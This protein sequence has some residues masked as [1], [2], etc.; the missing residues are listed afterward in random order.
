MKAAGEPPAS[1]WELG[2]EAQASDRARIYQ[3]RRDLYVSERD[4]HVHYVDDVH[5]ARR[6]ESG[7]GPEECPYPGL[8]AFEAQQAQWFFGRDGLTADLLVRL[9]ER[10]WAGGPL[11]VV[12]PSG[13]GKSSLLRAG[14]LPALARGALPVAGSARWPRALLTPTVHPLDALAPHLA[15]VADVSPQRAA[16]LLAD[17]PA[18]CMAM[19]HTALQET[20]GEYGTR[21]RWLVVVDQLEEL[22]TLCTSEE[23]GSAFLDVLG[24]IAKAGPAGEEPAGLVVFGLRSDFYTRCANQPHLRAALQDSPVVLGPMSETEVRE[25]TL[26]PARAVGLE[27]EP[28]L[29]EV[30]LRDLGVHA[31]AG[32][33]GAPA[34]T[35]EP[36]G[37]EAG[38][39]PLLAHALRA[40]WQQRHG[41]V[42]TVEGYRATGGIA[43]A[44]A[45]TADTVYARMDPLGQRATR[46]LFLRLVK[47]GTGVEDA[48]RR[49]PYT[50]L[51]GHGYSAATTAA[52]IE[53]FTQ[54]RLLTRERD[55]VEI[56]HEVLLRAWPRLRH[57][58]E[59]DRAGN[60]IRQELE[61]AAADWDRARRDAGMLYR[62]NRLE[63]ARSW[64]SARHQEQPSPTGSAF[65]AASLRQQRR[66]DR[67]RRAVISVLALL[68]L[69][70]SSA[71]LIAFRQRATAQ[72][73]RDTAIFNQVSAEADQLRNIDG[74]LAAQLDLVAHHMRPNDSKVYADLVNAANVPLSTPLTGHTSQVTS[75]VFSPDG[76][77]LASA[78]DDRTIRLWNV[79]D[80]TRP[81]RLGRALTGH[82]DTAESVAFSPDGHTLASASKDGT[83]RL[84]NVTDPAH[85]GKASQI[86]T[87]HAQAVRSVA[88]SPDGRILASASDDHTVRL[89]KVSDPAHPG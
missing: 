17:G 25:A 22:F 62:G 47:I 54:A 19:L 37:Y 4:L 49:L 40:T 76:R 61:E 53:T 79:T 27:V 78:S 50:D 9:D 21:R 56:T 30:L 75:A 66:T 88:F 34:R 74:S 1:G 32:T 29:A 59:D 83:V 57:W 24:A 82:S 58:I 85:P 69:I 70:A 77:I 73:E 43:H 64:A 48:R 11:V 10:L 84:W 23:E 13:A 52:I 67:L 36:G 68:V 26:F 8:A 18:A 41:H 20:D 6:V 86:L 42:L 44:I 63:A 81:R 39:L 16:E 80:P 55:S 33:T 5:T 46:A 71:A 87:G 45:T 89:W 28:G 31:H 35:R 51:A 14:L 7:T 12:A 65:L 72:T 3:A 38:R 2:L 60:L 15:R